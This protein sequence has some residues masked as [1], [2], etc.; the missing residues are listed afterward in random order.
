VTKPFSVP[1]L[2]ARVRAILRRHHEDVP[3]VL[4]FGDVR[5]EPK[6]YQVYRAEVLVDLTH[7][8]FDVLM[9]LVRAGGSAR[10]RAQIFE[11]VWGE[12]HHGTHRTID[13]FVAQ[14]R[15]KLEDDPSKPTFLLTVRGVGYRL[16]IV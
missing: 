16:A 15:A 14:L 4:Q 5:I 9:T 11:A 6:T 3:T 7:T 12:D 8:E 13:N 2:L 1:E 10:S